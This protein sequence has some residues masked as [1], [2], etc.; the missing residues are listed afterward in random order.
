MPFIY[1]PMV[2]VREYTIIE[3]TDNKYKVQYTGEDHLKSIQLENIS[4]SPEEAIADY[5][6]IQAD[7]LQKDIVHL[8]QELDKLNNKLT[9]VL[10]NEEYK[11]SKELFPEK[12]F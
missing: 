9:T 6:K 3:K 4:N 5:Y 2:G 8:T 1:T 7:K 10:K 12:F 11:K